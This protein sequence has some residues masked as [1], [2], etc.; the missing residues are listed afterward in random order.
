MENE[1]GKDTG[2]WDAKCCMSCFC[3]YCGNN[4]SCLLLKYVCCCPS[5]CKGFL[6]LNA[7][8]TP[9]TIRYHIFNIYDWNKKEKCNISS[10]FLNWSYLFNLQAKW[11]KPK[12]SYNR[13]T[14]QGCL[15]F[16]IIILLCEQTFSTWTFM[17]K[18]E[19]K[20]EWHRIAFFGSV[21]LLLFTKDIFFN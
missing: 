18:T 4:D 19:I 10:M 3:F 6:Y 8:S 2:S 21:L 17:V 5:S 1:K 12:P 20:V 14:C 11:N 16:C 9:I 7:L 13:K 15:Q